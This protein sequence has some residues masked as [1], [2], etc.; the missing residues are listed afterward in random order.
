M[1]TERPV[2]RLVQSQDMTGTTTLDPFEQV[3]HVKHDNIRPQYWLKEI[4]MDRRKIPH[5]GISL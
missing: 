5:K 3:E 2:G 4:S 1:T